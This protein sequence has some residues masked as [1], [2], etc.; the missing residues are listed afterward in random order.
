LSIAVVIFVDFKFPKF[1][2]SEMKPISIV[3]IY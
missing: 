2:N 1:G 3:V